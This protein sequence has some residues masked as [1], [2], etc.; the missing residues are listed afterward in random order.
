MI[1]RR[2]RTVG[3]AAL[4]LHR[5]QPILDQR[6]DLTSAEIN[7]GFSAKSEKDAQE[8]AGWLVSEL[9]GSVGEIPAGAEEEKAR[10]A[11]TVVEPEQTAL[12]DVLLQANFAQV[13]ERQV[14]KPEAGSPIVGRLWLRDVPV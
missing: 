14:F 7:F 8:L 4:R 1:R 9:V 10:I 11:Y 12:E 5:I 2:C 6:Q 3:S 13:G